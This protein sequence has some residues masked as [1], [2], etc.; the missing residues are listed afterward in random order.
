MLISPRGCRS[1]QLVALPCPGCEFTPARWATG[2]QSSRGDR[3]RSETAGQVFL[4]GPRGPPPADDQPPL[5]D[6]AA[7]CCCGSRPHTTH[8][9][10]FLLHSRSPAAQWL[11]GQPTPCPFLAASPA[12]G[13]TACIAHASP[14]LCVGTWALLCPPTHHAVAHFRASCPHMGLP[15]GFRPSVCLQGSLGIG[16]SLQFFLLVPHTPRHTKGMA[17]TPSGLS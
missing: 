17:S 4:P 10:A 12:P 5:G 15:G 8:R 2:E 7:Q 11:L 6:E 9:P 13:S 1:G 16:L 3:N 14:G